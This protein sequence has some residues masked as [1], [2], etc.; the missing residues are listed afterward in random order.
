MA[1]SGSALAAARKAAIDAEAPFN[2]EAETFAEYRLRIMAADSGAIVSY[3][4]AN[5]VVSTVVSTPDTFT[6]TGTGT[7]S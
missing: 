7:I 6:G 1:L 3:L 2:A 4:T 5:A